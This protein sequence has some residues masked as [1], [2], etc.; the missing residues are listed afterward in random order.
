[1]QH[2]FNIWMIIDIVLKLVLAV[3]CGGLVG[4]I[5]GGDKNTVSFSTLILTCFTSAFLVLV[6]LK[7]NNIMANI[8]ISIAAVLIGFAIIGGSIIIGKQASLNSIINAITIWAVAG[9]GVAIGSGNFI[10]A[11]IAGLVMSVLL[12]IIYSKF[13][14]NSE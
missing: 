6:I 2:F 11:I 1:V 3:L 14:I 10:T 4:L 5:K 8:E 7:L 12:N 9:M 13:L